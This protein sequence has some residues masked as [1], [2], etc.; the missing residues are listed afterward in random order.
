MSVS[1]LELHSVLVATD[2]SPA[3]EKPLRHALAIARSYGA[4][5]YLAHVVS[6]LGL[7]MTGPEAITVAE[8]AVSR[9]AAHLEHELV[10]SG[11]LAGVEHQVMIR[12][13]EVWP[14]LDA[15]LRQEKIGL[16]VLGTHGRHGVR[17]LLLGSVAE[18]IFRQAEGMVLTVGPGSYQDSRVEASVEKRTFLFATD[19]GE[20]SRNALPYAVSIANQFKAKLVFLN[21]I[22]AIPLPEGMHRCSADELLDLRQKAQATHLRRLE[23]LVQHVPLAVSPEF[24]VEL[25]AAVT[26]SEKILETAENIQAEIIVMGLHRSKHVGAVTHLPWATAYDVVCRASCPVL[27]VRK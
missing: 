3:S 7:T 21:I 25:G 9:D 27:T 6:S 17:K 26:I 10:R 12:H 14:E 5:F 24:R 8:Q 19:F 23:E 13:G 22:P 18:Q 15:I 16:I 20:G 11:A 1:A 2:F 4:K